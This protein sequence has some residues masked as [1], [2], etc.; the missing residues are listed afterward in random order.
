[1]EFLRRHARLAAFLVLAAVTAFGLWGLLSGGWRPALGHWRAKA[2]VLC[3][4]VFLQAADIA[5]DSYLWSLILREFKIRYSRK[6]GT[7][8]FLSGYAGLLLPWQ[9]GRFIRSDAI[10]RLGLG[11]FGEAV[12]AELILL[13][14]TGVAAIA[15]VTGV[16]TYTVFPW[17]LPVAVPAVIAVFLL[18]ADRLFALLARTPVKLPPRYWWRWRTFA[19]GCLAMVGWFI[20]GSILYLVVHDLPGSIVYNQAL[21]VAPA[22]LLLGVATGLPGGV[23]AIE[24]FMGVSLRLLDM[25]PAHLALAVG[26]FRLV[27]FWM[28]LPVG[29]LAF[30]TVNRLALRRQDTLEP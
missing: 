3:L 19:I 4:C 29:W 9:A 28:W 10:A 27:T 12:K 2:P 5:F 6:I 1:M 7:L 20:N 11:S 30:A 18:S 15:V 14:L 13:F 26:A 21:F 24:G 17:A 16:A 23:G 25:P 8:I 22:N